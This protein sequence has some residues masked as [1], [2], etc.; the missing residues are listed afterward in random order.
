MD[1][2]MLEHWAYVRVMVNVLDGPVTFILF[3]V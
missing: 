1:F 3:F 2:L